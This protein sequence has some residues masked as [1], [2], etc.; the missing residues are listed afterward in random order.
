MLG[1]SASRLCGTDGA[2]R[3]SARPIPPR[4]T[5][6]RVSERLSNERLVDLYL[7]HL[8]VERNLSANTIAAYAGDLSSLCAWAER[9]K[10]HLLDVDH[11]TLRRFLGELDRARYAKRTV[12]RRL[13]AVRSFYRFCVM[14]GFTPSSPAIVLATPKLP[15]ELPTVAPA[16]L[17]AT[18]IETP[19]GASADGVRDQAILELLYATGVRVSELSGL[20]TRDVDLSGGV[21][22]VMGKG[23]KER[24]VPMHPV[25]VRRL[26]EYFDRGRP[27]LA[28]AAS[29]N[30]VFLNRRGT[31]FMPGGIRRMLERHLKTLGASSQLTPHDLRHSFATH[32][33]EGG[34]DLRTVQELL[35]HVALSTTQIYTH[36]S[37][38]HL[39]DVH[40]GAHPR[41]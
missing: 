13:A 12:A 40:K 24:I 33:L 32:L 39:R 34:A 1:E 35:G 28:G 11:R 10:V 20:D 16:S 7:E 17:L 23:S 4:A 9:E 29:G 25:A 41:A 37:T 22:R 38:K 36:V 19:D 21:L 30:A 27:E 5:G 8:R 18:L 6:R 2:A 3:G 15:R 14:R 31:R 26:Q